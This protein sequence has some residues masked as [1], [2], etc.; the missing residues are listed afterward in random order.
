MSADLCISADRRADA[1]VCGT[2]R[3]TARSV[4]RGRRFSRTTARGITAFG[5]N[6]TEVAVSLST[7]AG[8]ATTTG[9]LGF[10]TSLADRGIVAA[11]LKFCVRTLGLGIKG[12]FAG[13][14]ARGCV[15]RGFDVLAVG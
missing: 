13:R 6:L 8:F 3:R 5:D 15:E 9:F 11:L 1:I 14:A 2:A 10:F 7:S 4:N 12:L